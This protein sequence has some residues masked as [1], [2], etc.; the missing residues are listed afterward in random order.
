VGA[1]AVTLI[2]LDVAS[3]WMESHSM[4]E[5][6]MFWHRVL[7]RR[8]ELYQPKSGEMVAIGE[9]D[10]ITLDRDVADQIAKTGRAELGVFAGLIVFVAYWLVAGPL[11]YTA[12]KRT[13][14]A[15]HAWVGFVLTAGVF[16]AIAWGGAMAIRPQQVQ[17]SHLTLLDH[18]YGQPNQRARSWI[19]LLVPTYGQATLA[20]ADPTQNAPARFS[21]IVAPWE[22][23]NASSSAFPDA[24]GY[25]VDS[26]A[27][28]HI[29]FPTRATVKQ[30][31]LDWAGGATWKMP[32]PVS[33][34]PDPTKARLWLASEPG[35]RSA[36]STRVKMP[37]R[38]SLV[39]DL[40]GPLKDVVILVNR[41]QRH[42]TGA[43][44]NAGPLLCDIG[45]YTYDQWKPG[46]ILDLE[47][48]LATLESDPAKYLDL[49]VT[50]RIGSPEG[51]TAPDSD[52]ARV[53]ARQ[54][55][56]ALMPQ[57]RPP[58]RPGNSNNRD[59]LAQRRL[60]HGWDLGMWFTQPC[61][62]IIGQLGQ[63]DDGPSTPIPLMV[64]T[65]G[66]YRPVASAGRTV[67][68]W[69]YPL[70]PDPPRVPPRAAE[71]SPSP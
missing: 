30:F 27:P 22:P 52:P 56:L 57:L 38:G 12:L 16:T 71:P 67:V 13:G 8:G 35:D 20:F 53:S 40:P 4:P 24:R 48:N 18:V 26:R 3:A 69:V 58:E 63:R 25:R 49:L 17:A 59:R 9:R 66:S 2:G 11:G 31:Q 64:S 47:S 70:P 33:A 10:V 34:D 39:H 41:G 5:P 28:D 68:R 45:A 50:D 54:V 62:I 15:Q 43:L 14:R 6:E 21:S 44:G 37:I 23:D 46:E 7:G 61:V 55:A 42:I 19:S 36:N 1:G 51:L 32:H 65:G 60:A 29:T